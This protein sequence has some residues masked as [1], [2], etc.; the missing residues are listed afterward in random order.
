LTARTPDQ[1]FRATSQMPITTPAY[2][3][4]SN[5]LAEAFVGTR[6]PRLFPSF[7]VR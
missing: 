6:G 4:E 3:P 7:E 2:S 1:R 5:G